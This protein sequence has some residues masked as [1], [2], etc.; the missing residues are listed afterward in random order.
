MSAGVSARWLALCAALTLTACQRADDGDAAALL[1]ATA[2]QLAADLAARRLT[3]VQVVRA[4]L[5]RIATLDDSGPELNAIIEINPDAIAIAEALDRHMADSGPVGPLHG[6]PVVL[7]ANIDTADRMATTAGSLA[8][9]D[10]YATE[11]AALVARLRAAGAVI[12]AKANLSEWA[13]FRGFRSSSGWSSLGGQ[14]KNPYVLDHSPCGSSSGSAVAVAARMVPLAVGTETDGS[15]VCP[16]AMNGVV[17]IKPTYGRVSTQGIIP[18]AAHLD[19]AGPMARTVRGAALLLAA[20]LDDPAAARIAV[21]D[22]DRAD[23]NGIRLGVLRDYTGVGLHADVESS[24]E[25][26]LTVLEQSGA[27]LIDPVELE[28]PGSF[29]AAELEFMSSEFKAGINEYLVRDAAWPDTLSELIEF[30]AENA[31]VVMPHFGQELFVIA[32]NSAEQSS[33]EYDAARAGSVTE[34]RERLARAFAAA[35]LDALVA[36]VTAPAF[37]I[38]WENGDAFSVSSSHVA[39]VSGYPSVVVPAGLIAGLPVAIAFV[40]PPDAEDVLLEIAA[41]FEA[42]RGPLQRPRFA[43]TIAQLSD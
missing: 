5:E 20:M 31:A 33:P 21:A 23:L 27:E 18:V 10:H 9:A 3:A 25:E 28:L 36:P 16:A 6:M 41:V 43:A 1:D 13:N 30:N 4:A 15:I 17:G 8:L 2:P 40:G 26:W 7:K 35:E 32:Q 34:V 22:L 38:D 37:P 11:D 19:V 29:G 12:V 39:A 14:T 42:S 24:F